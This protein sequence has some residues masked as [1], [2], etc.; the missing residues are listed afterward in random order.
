MNQSRTG[1]LG[2]GLRAILWGNGGAW[3]VTKYLTLGQIMQPMAEAPGLLPGYHYKPQT[4][5]GHVRHSNPG[6]VGFVIFSKA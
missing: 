5:S 3:S 6:S 2:L 4:G 1:G